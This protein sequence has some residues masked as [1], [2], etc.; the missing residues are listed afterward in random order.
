[1]CVRVYPQPYLRQRTTVREAV[2]IAILHWIAKE[3]RDH[4]PQASAAVVQVRGIRP[5]PHRTD[6]TKEVPQHAWS[7]L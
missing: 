3:M 7:L 6:L 1:M 4:L 5:C 2:K